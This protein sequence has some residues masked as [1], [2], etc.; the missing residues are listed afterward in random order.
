MNEQRSIFKL[1]ILTLY[2]IQGM[3]YGYVYSLPLAYP[4]IPNYYILG[5]FGLSALPF[6]FKFIIGNR[7]NRQLLLSKDII[8]QPMAKEKLGLSPPFFFAP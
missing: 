2:L 4:S 7:Y 3:F 1:M 8:I 5:L 6:S